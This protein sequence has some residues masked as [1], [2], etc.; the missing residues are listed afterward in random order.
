MAGRAGEYPRKGLRCRGI[1]LNRHYPWRKRGTDLFSGSS[2]NRVGEM[3]RMKWFGA[4]LAAGESDVN[5]PR[6]SGILCGWYEDG[7][8][9]NFM[10]P[11]GSAVFG[12]ARRPSGGSGTG[13][14]GASGY[15]AGQKK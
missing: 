5:G 9:F 6:E 1:R 8:I 12:R 15:F 14:R 11:I 2:R 3:A 4:A 10:T 7:D 13:T